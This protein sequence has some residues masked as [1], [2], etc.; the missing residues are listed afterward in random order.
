MDVVDTVAADFDV[1]IVA[2]AD[3]AAVAAGGLQSSRATVRR[4]SVYHTLELNIVLCDCDRSL[5]RNAFPLY[6]CCWKEE[7]RRRIQ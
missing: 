5:H 4:S 2:V 3:F 1:D 7:G 6:Y